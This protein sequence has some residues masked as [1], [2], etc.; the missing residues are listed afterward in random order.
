MQDG[1]TWLWNARKEGWEL[2]KTSKVLGPCQTLKTSETW[3]LSVQTRWARDRERRSNL[4][5][6]GFAF[7]WVPPCPSCAVQQPTAS[8]RHSLDP[9]PCWM[10]AVTGEDVRQVLS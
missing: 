7:P 6:S 9:C 3:A 1:L 2:G 5:Q 8:C 10:A 4:F